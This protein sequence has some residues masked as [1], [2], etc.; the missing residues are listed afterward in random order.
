MKKYKGYL[1]DLDGTM[2]RGNEP[3]EAAREF[4]NHLHNKKIPY[5]F[6]TNNSSRTQEDI[7]LKLNNM[8][9]P[10]TPEQ[11]V[12]SSAATAIYLNGLKKGASC[13]VIGEEGLQVALE[14]EGLLITEEDNCDFVVMG[15][16]RNVTYEKY[17]KACLAI[18][19]G[20]T[21]IATNNDKAIPTER[22]LLPGNGALVSVVTVSTGAKPIIIGKP[23][24]IIMEAALS[25]LVLN[26]ED[27]AMIGDNYD[28]DICAGI[29]AG[30]D[31]IMVFT[32]VTSVEELP[33]L[34]IKPTYH[35]SSLQEWMEFI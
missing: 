22:G 30:M 3:I 18:R 15:I 16:D 29:N 23:E 28:T 32:G 24:S 21:F 25:K 11:V 33:D 2:Y 12:N 8:G 26:K 5:V 4:V 6:V 35:V 20:A 27:I 34:K 19:K 9:V 14:D 10:S 7:S 17:T 1:I 31:T 13:Y